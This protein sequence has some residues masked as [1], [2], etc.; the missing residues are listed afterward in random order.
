MELSAQQLADR[1][2][3]KPLQEYYKVPSSLSCTL[4]NALH[5]SRHPLAAGHEPSSGQQ[6]RQD[7]HCFAWP[8]AS[9]L[10]ASVYPLCLVSHIWHLLACRLKWL[11]SNMSSPSGPQRTDT[12][13]Q[14]QVK[15][16][17]C[18]MGL[19]R[20][21]STHAPPRDAV[22]SALFCRGLSA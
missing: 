1:G 2:L 18:H 21:H 22:A 16:C 19:F 7:C 15:T 4:S 14:A 6:R 13:N 10:V 17:K 9:P 20:Q 3:H 5:C 12:R 11:S 8:V